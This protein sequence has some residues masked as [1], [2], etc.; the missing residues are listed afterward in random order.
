MTITAYLYGG[1][2]DGEIREL[3]HPTTSLKF[4]VMPELRALETASRTDSTIPIVGV[5][6]YRATARI[7]DSMRFEYLL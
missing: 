2:R 6:E 4:P 7:G 5:I 3:T 1:P